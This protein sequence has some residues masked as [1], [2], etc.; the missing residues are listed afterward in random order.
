MD[1]SYGVCCAWTAAMAACL[2][3]KL[4]HLC[5]LGANACASPVHGAAPPSRCA[6]DETA[7]MKQLAVLAHVLMCI[8]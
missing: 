7:V 5:M 6:G 3:R 2:S 4:S 1:G 8:I